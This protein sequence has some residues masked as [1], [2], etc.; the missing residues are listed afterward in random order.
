MYRQ[1]KLNPEDWNL[2]II[3]WYNSEQKITPYRLTTVTYGLNCAPFLVLRT[4]QQLIE[5]E[6]HRFPLS[7]PP[8]TKGRYVDNIFG[9]AETVHEAQIII[10]QLTQITTAGGFSLQK[11]SSNCPEILANKTSSSI[12]LE[13]THTKILGLVRQPSTDCFNFSSWPSH[14]SVN[15]KRTVLSEIAQL[16]DPLKF[17][18]PETIRAK[19]FMKELWLAKISWNDPLPQP[20]HHRWNAFQHQLP[21]LNEITIPRWLK[22]SSTNKVIELHG[23][24][25]ASLLA[26]A[27]VI[28][29]KVVDQLGNVSIT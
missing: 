13:P 21:I 17:L 10:Q 2:Q 1:I 4:I 15:T 20:L 16:Y 6:G 7:I 11:W 24:S 27:A 5:D 3:F 23:F 19:I 22:I 25:N 8:L 29:I 26:M 28:Y 18:S 14:K 12:K 9:G